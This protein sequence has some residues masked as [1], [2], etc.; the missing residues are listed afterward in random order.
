[1]NTEVV[2]FEIKDVKLQS[3]EVRLIPV[4]VSFETKV[5]SF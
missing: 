4:Y 2:Q 1:L 5:V 3:V